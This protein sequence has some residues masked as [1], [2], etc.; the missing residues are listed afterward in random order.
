[1]EPSTSWVLTLTIGWPAAGTDVHK[2]SHGH[3]KR[4]LFHIIMKGFYQVTPECIEYACLL[5]TG[6]YLYNVTS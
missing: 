3:F 1:M 4:S 6:R 2:Q 5:K